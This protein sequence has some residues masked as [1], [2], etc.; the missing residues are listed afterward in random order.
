V[1][2]AW[3]VFRPLTF[4]VTVPYF[5][6]EAVDRL[7]TDHQY[8]RPVFTHEGLPRGEIQ[9]VVDATRAAGVRGRVSYSVTLPLDAAERQDMAERL[10]LSGIERTR[11]A[12]EAA[13]ALSVGTISS[14]SQVHDQQE[15]LRIGG[16]FDAATFDDEN[17]GFPG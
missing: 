7:R 17:W 13:E 2:V 5:L 16:V 9:A 11:E 15:T 1:K 12:L 6:A 8:S 4:D 10:A 3:T 14:L